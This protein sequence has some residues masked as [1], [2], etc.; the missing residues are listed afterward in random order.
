MDHLLHIYHQYVPVQV[1]NI[2]QMVLSRSGV[3][4]NCSRLR[5][6]KS[7][8]IQSD[9]E[10]INSCSNV[11]YFSDDLDQQKQCR[12]PNIEDFID[13]VLFSNGIGVHGVV[14][15]SKRQCHWL[16]LRNYTVTRHLYSQE[17]QFYWNKEEIETKLVLRWHEFLLDHHP[18]LRVC[19]RIQLSTYQKHFIA[20]AD[21]DYTELHNHLDTK[22]HQQECLLFGVRLFQEK[23][24]AWIVGFGRTQVL[25]RTDH[26]C[27]A[28]RTVLFRKFGHFRQFEWLQ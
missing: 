23:V 22:H 14:H 24:Y 25:F 9:T 2:D 3:D 13:G 12:N 19:L 11:H 20:L 21:S 6:Q 26:I 27:L 4:L 17:D 7:L 15:P 18:S 10:W 28:F 8:D 5:F 16:L 1:Q